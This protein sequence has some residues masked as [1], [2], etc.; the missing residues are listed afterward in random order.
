MILILYQLINFIFEQ[1]E[2][3]EKEDLWG[4]LEWVATG[5]HWERDY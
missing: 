5:K 4:H 2:E 3:N 1:E